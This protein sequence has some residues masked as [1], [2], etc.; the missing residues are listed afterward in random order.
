V[1]SPERDVAAP[2]TVVL[3]QLVG[4][5]GGRDVHRHHDHVGRVVEIER[6]DVLVLEGRLVVGAQIP[7]K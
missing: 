5:L 3:G 2:G 4:A 6:H 1:K 7:R